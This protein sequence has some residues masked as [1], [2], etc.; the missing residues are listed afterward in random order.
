MPVVALL[1]PGT[2]REMQIPPAHLALSG[3]IVGYCDLSGQIVRC[4]VSLLL[5]RHIIY[6]DISRTLATH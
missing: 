4:Y 3:Q 1:L 2:G 5:Y 6:V